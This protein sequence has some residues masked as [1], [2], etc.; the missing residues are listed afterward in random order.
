M[1][2]YPKDGFMQKNKRWIT[3]LLLSSLLMSCAFLQTGPYKD[4]SGSARCF[5]HFPDQDGWYGGDGA[6][7]IP[8]D[9]QRTL[10]LFGDTFVAHEAGRKDRIG[11]EVVMGTT[12]AISRC[13]AKAEFQIQYYLKKK[14]GI[15]VS[16][17]GETE[18]LW[19]QDPFIAD[20]TLYIPL[21]II[22]ALPE[23]P[24][25]FNF[26]IAGHKIVRIKDYRADDPHHWTIEYLNWTN[27]LPEGIEALATTSVVHHDYV[28]FFPLYRIS[29]DKTNIAGNILARI[30]IIKLNTPAEALEYLNR[31][32]VWEKKFTP[33]TV[34]IVLHATVSELSVRYHPE[35]RQWMAVYLSPDD[36]GRRL[37]YQ[38]APKL[39]GPW[40]KALPMLDA[41]PEV[42][43]AS[44][45]YNKYTFCYAGKEHRQY[46]QNKNLVVTYV[47]NSSEGLNQSAGFLYTN[48]FLYRPVVKI[49]AVP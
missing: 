8:L 12:L 49:L 19:P 11:M 47:C 7:S 3:L 38:T 25:P 31:D 26:K 48:L 20:T 32:G 28:Y 40:S 6:Y 13:S 17:F 36:K 18:W 45:L 1:K 34:K 44:P 23:S 46:A 43:P 2:K 14:N 33:E 30:P 22:E 37:L 21:L 24:Q 16:S 27:A 39:E 41:I 35:D 9:E 5:P 15:F 4:A 10:W 29:K 42:D